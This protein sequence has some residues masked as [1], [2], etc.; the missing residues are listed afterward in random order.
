MNCFWKLKNSGVK[1][2]P[3]KNSAYEEQSQNAFRQIYEQFQISFT[4]IFNKHMSHYQNQK[5]KQKQKTDE[6]ILSNRS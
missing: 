3:E 1:E 2:N 5:K 4:H 6:Q